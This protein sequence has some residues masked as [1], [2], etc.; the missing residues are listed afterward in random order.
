MSSPVSKTDSIL[1]M[2]PAF[3]WTTTVDTSRYTKAIYI[4]ETANDSVDVTPNFPS[5]ASAVTVP[6]GGQFY[7]LRTK[8]ALTNIAAGYTVIYLY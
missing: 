8:T 6:L 4:V 2:A 1:S 3:E 7:P 5:G